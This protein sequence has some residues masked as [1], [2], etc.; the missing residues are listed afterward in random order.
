M[1]HVS[2]DEA[3]ATGRGV[4]RPFNCPEHDDTRASASVNVLKGVWWCYACFAHGEVGEEHVPTVEEALAI[5]AGTTPP[6]VLP[7][8]WLDVFDADHASP[9]WTTRY[10]IEVAAANRCGTDPETGFPTYPLR[11]AEGRLWGVV[12]RSEAGPDKYRYP[13]NTS[14]SRTLYGPPGPAQVVVLVEGASDVMALQ[15]AGIPDFWSVRGC[16]GAGLHH[17]QVALVGAS[18][19]KVVLAAFDDD[20]A[21]LAAA[22]RAVS[23]LTD[24]APVLSV[25]WSRIGS[26]VTDPGMA[27]ASARVPAL[28][29]TLR[30][31]GY[32]RYAA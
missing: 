13:W 2:L 28:S 4:E 10:G 20:K 9:Y 16:F 23:V 25:R 6:R 14:T 1:Q 31:Q 15:E 32:A 29:D 12:T 27:P 30:E 18:A 11:D 17:P 5:L 7:E 8:A 26:A 3:L 21:G 24:V 19:P 22:E